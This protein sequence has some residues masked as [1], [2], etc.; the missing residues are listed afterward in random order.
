MR[1]DFFFC[2]TDWRKTTLTVKTNGVRDTA[3]KHRLKNKST[4]IYDSKKTVGYLAKL[5]LELL[6]LSSVTSHGV[7]QQLLYVYKM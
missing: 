6:K 7:K 4:E 1:R 5:E 2:V 3:G